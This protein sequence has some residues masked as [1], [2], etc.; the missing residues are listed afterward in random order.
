[1]PRHRWRTRSV[2]SSHLHPRRQWELDPAVF[3]FLKPG[4]TCAAEVGVAP[5]HIFCR[6]TEVLELAKTPMIPSHPPQSWPQ[7]S[8]QGHPLGYFR[9]PQPSHYH[10]RANSRPA[11]TKS[12]ELHNAVNA[13][14]SMT[15]Q[16]EHMKVPIARVGPRPTLPATRTSCPGLRLVAGDSAATRACAHTEI[17]IERKMAMH[18]IVNA[19]LHMTV[20]L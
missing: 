7:T 13:A 12:K 10:R 1:M 5:N 9:C 19:K 18:R 8:R 15:P 16:R 2:F 6:H 14:L 17:E 4:Y 3:R 11:K 20:R